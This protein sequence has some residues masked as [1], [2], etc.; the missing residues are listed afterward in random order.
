[1]A[2]ILESIQKTRFLPTR[3]LKDELPTFQG[4][5][6]GGK[7]SHLMGL[8]KRLSSFSGKIQPISSAS[9]EWA[10]RRSK[11]APS[12]GAA[13]AAGGGSLRQW[14]K[15]GVGWLLSKKPGFAGDL[16][17]NEEEVAALGRQSRGSWG[18]ILYKMRAGVRRLVMSSH[19]L[20]TTQ[21][22]VAAGC[23]RPSPPVSMRSNPNGDAQEEGE[24]SDSR[25]V[26][27]MVKI[28]RY[29]YKWEQKLAR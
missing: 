19:S 18:H 8:R 13:F 28:S 7:E 6:G 2:T 26:R 25:C 21:K 24:D 12:L 15:W 29:E 1:M 14:W 9:A 22:H 27:P 23:G 11:S 4:G 10:F 16:E 20:P 17:M 5:L 3:P